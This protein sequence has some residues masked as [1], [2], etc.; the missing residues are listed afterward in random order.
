MK[1]QHFFP[2][3][4]FLQKCRCPFQMV[5]VWNFP[6]LK[7]N[8]TQRRSAKKFSTMI[9]FVILR[10]NTHKVSNFHPYA[11]KTTP[12][13]KKPTFSF[14]LISDHFS[15]FRFFVG[16]T[17]VL[18]G[19]NSAF[20]WISHFRWNL[21]VLCLFFNFAE[22]YTQLFKLFIKMPFFLFLGES[23]TVKCHP[24]W[25]FLVV[26]FVD[27]RS[28]EIWIYFE[29]FSRLGIPAGEE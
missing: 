20:S 27:V 12:P 26:I 19:P 4:V 3:P 13:A 2:L 18:K 6:V 23:H 17:P 21:S 22:N 11:G 25:K 1:I 16:F 10:Q 15:A 7:A 8:H 14:K 5:R 29:H 24:G 28:G 9:P